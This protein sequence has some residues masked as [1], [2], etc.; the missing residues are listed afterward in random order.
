MTPQ[1]LVDAVVDAILAGDRAGLDHLLRTHSEMPE[2]RQLAEAV[3]EVRRMLRQPLSPADR[4]RHRLRIQETPAMR[5][6][7]GAP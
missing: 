6:A 5:D 2:M 3:Q 7:T 4:T 1:D